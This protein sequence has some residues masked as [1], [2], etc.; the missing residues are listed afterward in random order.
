MT[1]L[2]EMAVD[3]SALLMDIAGCINAY[4]LGTP[5]LWST[6][7]TT[8]VLPDNTRI[9]PGIAVVIAFGKLHQCSKGEGGFFHGPPNL[10]IDTFPGDSMLD[11]AERCKLFR[12][13]GVQEY[14]AWQVG[15]PRPRWLRLKDGD[16]MEL[17]VAG[18]ETI[19]S[20][21]LPGFML[22]MPAVE[23]R[24]WLAI[25]AGIRNGTNSREH[26]AFIYEWRNRL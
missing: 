17:D 26:N 14:I 1:L 22:N 19:Q 7:H 4:Q 11:F 20:T 5:G 3:E 6:I 23:K 9:V 21:A 12:K 13:N 8:I 2:R 16:Y 15:M 24:D 25:H 10:V 18:S